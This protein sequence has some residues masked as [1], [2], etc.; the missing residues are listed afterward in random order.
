MR[1]FLA[2]YQESLQKREI[3]SEQIFENERK[4]F[5]EL[6]FEKF[7]IF[8]FLSS[9]QLSEKLH[10]DGTEEISWISLHPRLARVL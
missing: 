4:R 7:N 10:Y 6:R 9:S 3:F 8:S 2:D 5:D 1:E